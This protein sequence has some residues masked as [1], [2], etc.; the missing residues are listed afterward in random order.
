MQIPL[1]ENEC[2]TGL[3]FIPSVIKDGGFGEII[4][5]KNCQIFL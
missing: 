4:K 2:G 3:Q 5:T 1:E